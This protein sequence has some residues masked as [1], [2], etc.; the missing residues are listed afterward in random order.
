MS[1]RTIALIPARGG[2][3]RFPGK[4]V[5]P[6][7][8]KPLAAWTLDFAHDCGLFD[9]IYLNTDMAEVVALAH[10]GMKLCARPPELAH[11]KATL[12]EVI[13]YTCQEESFCSDDIL[14][15]LP[16][17]GPLRTRTDLEL[18]LD[19]FH[20][21]DRNHTVVSV[22]ESP[23]PAG[24]LW[25][26]EGS[27]ALIPLLPERYSVTTQKQHHQTTYQFNDLFV[28]DSVE[29]FFHRERNLFG[30]DPH[31]VVIPQE[32]SMPIDYEFQ[33]VLAEALYMRGIVDGIFNT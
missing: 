16:V 22:N 25:T 9:D 19:Q 14:V 27:D 1:G 23:Y 29:G 12:L 8:G 7:N 17:T 11:D 3:K 26:K 32:R 6:F 28:I 10:N 5:H 30:L 21:S 18:G 2:S 33:F 31:A 20:N 13:R 4:N 24:M 15:L